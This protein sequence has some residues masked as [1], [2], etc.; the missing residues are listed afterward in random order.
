M[1][2]GEVTAMERLVES[3]K[4]QEHDLSVML[5]SRGYRLV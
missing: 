3:K 2:K 5:T 1:V 4:I